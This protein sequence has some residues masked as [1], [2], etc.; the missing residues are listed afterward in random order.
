MREKTVSKAVGFAYLVL[1]LG[2][3]S[4]PVF[5]S[6][7][8]SLKSSAEIYTLPPSWIPKDIHVNNYL[9]MFKVLPLS[10]AF[11][12]SVIVALGSGGLTLGA[13]LPAGYALARLEFPGRRTFLFLVL[14]SIMFS[15]VVIIVALF[16]QFHSY[17]LLNTYASLIL[18][19]AT[20]A[21][22]FS[23]WLATAYIRSIPRELEEAASVDGA[24]R[25]RAL[26]HVIVPTSL[27]GVATVLIFGFI[28]AWNEFLLAYTFMITDNMKP[29]SVIM[30]SFVGYRGIEWQYVTGAI[31]LA[32]IPA[33]T[34]FLIVQRW[35]IGGL[36]LGAVK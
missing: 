35:L 29:L 15:P 11:L 34:L 23:I 8:T 36:T 7:I 20:F 5:V 10:R 21:L 9:N 33:V 1:M 26:W 27:P 32:A 6:L 25:A 30:Y 19:D 16:R 12:N 18:T 4:F 3:V 2:I 13:A 14:S 17:G 24:N 28:Q 22:P 31:L